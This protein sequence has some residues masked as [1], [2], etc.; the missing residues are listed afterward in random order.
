MATVK[1]SYI[2]GLTTTLTGFDENEFIEWLKDENRP[3][4]SVSNDSIKT[5]I[6]KDKICLAQ[7]TD[8][9]A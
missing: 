1:I 6:F 5:F 3:I 2:G 8:M 7:I 4:H 9:D